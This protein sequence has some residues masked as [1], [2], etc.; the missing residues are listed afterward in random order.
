MTTPCGDAALKK[1]PPT[2][3]WRGA[4][5]AFAGRDGVQIWF[6]SPVFSALLRHYRY[7][8]NSSHTASTQ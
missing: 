6:I 2:M 3:G 5:Q 4:G 8:R 1:A 7:L